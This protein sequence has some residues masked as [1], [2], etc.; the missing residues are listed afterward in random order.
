MPKLSL[1]V[2]YQPHAGMEVE[3]LEVMRRHAKACLEEEPGCLRFEIL[4]PLD[5]AGQPMANRLMANEL[6]TDQA[7]LA[8]H[9]STPRW[10][11][12]NDKFKVMLANRTPRLSWVED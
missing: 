4:R 9:R 12:L 8:F 1:I 3:F 11:A 10:Q 7:A 6:F 2:E 5:E